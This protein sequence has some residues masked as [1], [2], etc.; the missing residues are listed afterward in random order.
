MYFSMVLHLYYSLLF[1]IKLLLYRLFGHL[2]SLRFSWKNHCGKNVQMEFDKGASVS[3]GRNIG[4]RNAV[5]LSVRKGANLVIGNKVFINNGCNIVVHQTVLIGENTKFGQNVMVFDHDYD[6]KTE[7]G[8]SAKVYKNSD[9]IIGSN[10]WI[11]AGCII[12][13]GTRIGDNSVV[14]AGCVLKGDY[15]P[16]S[17]IIQKRNT[18]VVKK[19][20][21]KE[22][23]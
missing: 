13:R 16:N 6:Y 15:P 1:F 18:I 23:A 7:G 4:L 12:L 10:C 21:A 19:R 5:Y 14:G 3:L 22:D 2:R 17:I 9:V 8:V 20:S 11:G